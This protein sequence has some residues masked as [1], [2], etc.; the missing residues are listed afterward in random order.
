MTAQRVKGRFGAVGKTI[1]G[2][3]AAAAGLIG[4]WGWFYLLVV[5][6]QGYGGISDISMPFFVIGLVLWGVFWGGALVI[7]AGFFGRKSQVMRVGLRI[8]A[9]MF[10]IAII[11]PIVAAVT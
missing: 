1:G 9:G 3:L 8:T 4:A 10:S 7:V 6:V 5:S 11:T 2:T